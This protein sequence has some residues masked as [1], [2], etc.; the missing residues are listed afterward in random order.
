[1][2]QVLPKQSLHGVLSVDGDKSVTI[3]AIIFALVAKECVTIDNALIGGDSLAAIKCIIKLGATVNIN[4]NSI[5]V[6]PP[7]AIKSGAKLDCENSATLARLLIGLCSGLNISVTVSGDKSLLKR[8]MDRVCEPLRKRG[9]VISDNN[10]RLPVKIYPAKLNEFEYFMPNDSA[11]VKSAILLSGLSSGKKTIVYERNHSRN[12]TEKMLAY[13][14][15]NIVVEDKKITLLKSELNGC[16]IAVPADPSSAYYYL[17][18]G[19]MLGEITVK[20]LLLCKLRAGFLSVLH[21]A[22]GKFC[23]E[24]AVEKDGF[25]R[26]DITAYKSKIGFFTVYEE[27]LASL[28]DEVPLLALIAAKNGGCKILGGAEL[29]V[30]ESDRLEQTRK[31]VELL[32]GKCS[33]EKDCLI[34][35]P[36]EDKYF[37]YCSEDHRMLLTSFVAAVCG[38][39]AKIEGQDAAF[40]SFPSVYK[41]YYNMQLGLIGSDVSKSGSGRFHKFILNELGVRNFTYECRSVNDEQMSDALQKWGYKSINVTVPYKNKAILSN[42]KVS[43]EVEECSST[44]FIYNST[45]YNTDGIGLIYALNY[46]GVWVK[47]KSILVCGTG[48]AGRAIACALSKAGANVYVANRTKKTAEDFCNGKK[49]KISLD[50]GKA[51]QIIVNA[52]TNSSFDL[53]TEEQLCGAQAAIDINYGKPSEFLNAFKKIGGNKILLDGYPMLFFQAYICDC[54]LLNCKPEQKQAFEL[55]EKYK[56]KYEN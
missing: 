13:M 14:G 3:R 53:I 32:G 39:G 18:M 30:K 35:E 17:A 47:N 43:N 23:V 41:N 37:E 56:V 5:T 42:F 40:I 33:I 24:N 54:L 27:Q 25:L 26:G 11:Q 4:G 44:N 50:G 1:M 45:C 46:A 21:Q 28:I 9:A 12:H 15:A 52:T 8:P 31:L 48:G 38:V 29:R 6:I 2:M 10:G 51:C 20:N 34:V 36:G 55:Y 19:L 49:G 7:L 16:N 22:G